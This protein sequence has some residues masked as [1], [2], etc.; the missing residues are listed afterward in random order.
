M[1]RAS[2][3]PRLA[4]V[5]LGGNAIQDPEGDDSVASDFARTLETAKHLV[6]LSLAGPWRIVV[7]HGNGPQVGNHLLRSELGHEHGDL[8][9]LPL[10]VCVADTQGGMGY[11]LQQSLSDS[12]HAA[13]V[14]AVVV[15]VVTQVVVEPDDPAF[16][17]PTKPVGEILPD[18]RADEFR[19]KGWTLVKDERRGGWRRVVPSPDPREIVEAQAIK[20]MVQEGTIVVAAGGG[21]IP[22]VQAPDG[23]LHGRAA[24]VDKDLASALLAAD[25]GAD[26]LLILTDVE[27]VCLGFGTDEVEPLRE[28]TVADAA[29]YLAAGEFPAGSMGPKVEAV[30]RFVSATGGIGTITSIER[31]EDGLAG[32]AGTRVLP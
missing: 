29:R 20:A 14:P 3:E 11:M 6:A 23:S 22:V 2:G 12:F 27:E 13:G 15:A 18:E 9:E 21:G 31:A 5:A 8:P 28:L 17:D 26:A 7:T 24:V 1:T 19:S 4:V 16:G 30:R 25:L 32:R 10:D